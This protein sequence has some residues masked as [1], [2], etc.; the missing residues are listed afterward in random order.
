MCKIGRTQSFVTHHIVFSMAGEDPQRTT[1]NSTQSHLVSFQN[2]CQCLA[3]TMTV[4]SLQRKKEHNNRWHSLLCIFDMN[5]TSS[6]FW[7]FGECLC[8]YQ[9]FNQGL[10][11]AQVLQLKF[12]F[13]TIIIQATFTHL[14]VCPQLVVLQIGLENVTQSYCL[15]S[16]MQRD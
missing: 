7:F 4:K 3:I 16:Q 1:E 15:F 2:S 11:C 9:I 8:V 6:S 5:Q 14:S 13:L 10:K 12:W